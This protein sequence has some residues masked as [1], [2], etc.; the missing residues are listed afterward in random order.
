MTKEYQRRL[1]MINKAVWGKQGEIAEACGVKQSTVSRVLNGKYINDKILRK[2][3]EFKEMIE[4]Q[5]AEA[6][7]KREQLI[8]A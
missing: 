2:A 7:A 8:G 5:E 1:R 6:Q 4:Q 3:I